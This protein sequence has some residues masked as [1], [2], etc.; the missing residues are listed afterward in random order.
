MGRPAKPIKIGKRSGM[1]TVL[2]ESDSRKYYYKVKCDC[3]TIKEM[4]A[5]SLR[6]STSKSCG[7]QTFLRGLKVG[8]S[9]INYLFRMYVQAAK[10]RGLPWG[11]SKKRFIKL[12]FNPC[13]Y[14]G[15]GF[16]TAK[17]PYG[18]TSAIVTGVDRKDS[19]SGYSIRNCVS[20]CTVCNRMKW[21]L[22]EEDFFSKI[23]QI[24]KYQKR[25]IN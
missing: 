22:K 9:A 10:R 24:L 16:R 1:L 20:C 13:V 25:R 19:S 17:T 2:G 14:C 18:K 21:D 12:I 5:G 11:L 7:C 6:Y 23:K 3:G 4:W 8:E 15:S